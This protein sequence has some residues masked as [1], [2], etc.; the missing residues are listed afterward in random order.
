MSVTALAANQLQL[1]P[2]WSSRR[3][4]TGQVSQDCEWS[5]GDSLQE[6]MTSEEAFIKRYKTRNK[7]NR[8]IYSILCND[9]YGKRI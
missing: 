1:P 2:A 9:L 5:V 6:K 4:R 7:G 8:E 3:P